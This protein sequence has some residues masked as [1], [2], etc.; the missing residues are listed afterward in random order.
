[1]IAGVD[2]FSGGQTANE[3]ASAI[4]M[5]DDVLIV[6]RECRDWTA[7]KEFGDFCRH[8]IRAGGGGRMWLFAG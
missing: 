5:C 4:P 6:D 2:H 1:M 7:V 3:F 8:Q